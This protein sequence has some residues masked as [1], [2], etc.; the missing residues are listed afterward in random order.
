V[1]A[2]LEAMERHGR[3]RC[4]I[5][6]SAVG[7]LRRKARKMP[8]SRLKQDVQTVIGFQEFFLGGKEYNL[9][10]SLIHYKRFISF[11]PYFLNYYHY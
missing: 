11:T 2:F 1:E 7:S 9:N 8:E 3:R 6:G 4:R 5:G 10:E